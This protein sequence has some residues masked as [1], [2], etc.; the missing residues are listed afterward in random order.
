MGYDSFRRKSRLGERKEV[1]QRVCTT[2][3]GAAQLRMVDPGDHT[4]R[5]TARGHEEAD[6]R[7]V[8]VKVGEETK[9]TVALRRRR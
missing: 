9:V 4:I 2:R 8:E 6:A 1:L 7:D 3:D 5:V